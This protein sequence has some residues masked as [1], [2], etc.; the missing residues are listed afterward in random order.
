MLSCRWQWWCSPQP[1][2]QKGVSGSETLKIFQ[3][4][5]WD[6]KPH[7]LGFQGCHPGGKSYLWMLS[8]CSKRQLTM[9]CLKTQLWPRLVKHCR[10]WVWEKTKEHIYQIPWQ[11]VVFHHVLQ[12]C[13]AGDLTTTKTGRL[14]AT[15]EAKGSLKQ[16]TFL[17]AAFHMSPLQPKVVLAPPDC[18]W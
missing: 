7:M 14:G 10:M 2:F 9:W 1:S 13:R 3:V 5:Y 4:V 17:C 8:N 12:K 11:G 18:S 6:E 16:Q 15:R